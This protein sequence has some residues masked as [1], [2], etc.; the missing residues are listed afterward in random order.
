MTIK[1]DGF[2]YDGQLTRY[3]N[4]FMAIFQGLQVQVGKWNNE[5]I[6]LVPVDVHYGHMDRV[7]ASLMADNVQNKPLK[8]PT[9]SVYMSGLN[10][11]MNRARGVGQQRRSAYVPV[12]GLVPDDIEVVHQRMPVPYNLSFDLNIFVSNTNQHFQIMEQIL[13]LFDPSL[14]IQTSD[15]VFDWTRMTKVEL[16]DIMLNTNF[17]IGTDKRIIQSKIVFEMQIEIDTPAEVRKD[18][19]ERIYLRIGSVTDRLDNEYTI[20]ED[21]DAQG[22]QYELNASDENLPFN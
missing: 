1:Q 2:Y 21:L 3:V 7:V 8:L 10:I 9:M 12:G 13:P 20:L 17:P 22:L 14:T 19:I 4:Q 16:K 15:A 11:A 18:I 6:R 5:D